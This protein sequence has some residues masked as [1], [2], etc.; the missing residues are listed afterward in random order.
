MCKWFHMPF[1][2]IKWGYVE[3]SSI[4]QYE[5]FLKN[6]FIIMKEY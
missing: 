2:N 3:F 1:C 4:S 5:K 6:P